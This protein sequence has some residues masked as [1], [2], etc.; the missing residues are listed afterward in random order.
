MRKPAS[1]YGLLEVAKPVPMGQSDWPLRF[2]DAP[3]DLRN[4]DHPKPRAS[5]DRADSGAPK[6]T[7]WT[8]DRAGQAG[9]VSG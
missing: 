7:Y 9:D 1:A 2:D 4:W 8:D 5:E 3:P 6:S